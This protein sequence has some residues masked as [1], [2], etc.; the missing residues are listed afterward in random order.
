MTTLK[1][2]YKKREELE[3]RVSLNADV[4]EEQKAGVSSTNDSSDNAKIKGRTEQDKREFELGITETMK[5][6]AQRP[7]DWGG[8]GWAASFDKRKSKTQH[9]EESVG[10]KYRQF[11]EIAPDKE[12]RAAISFIENVTV[13]NQLLKE[14]KGRPIGEL[15]I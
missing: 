6:N 4:P 14:N 10:M 7:V 13:E 2:L 8:I 1:E 12:R 3:E 15:K 11:I 5:A 9:F